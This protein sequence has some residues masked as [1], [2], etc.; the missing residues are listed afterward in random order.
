MYTS[1]QSLNKHEKTHSNPL[2]YK[3]YIYMEPCEILVKG[4][5]RCKVLGPGGVFH[6]IHVVADILYLDFRT[7]PLKLARHLIRYGTF[8][9][10][11]C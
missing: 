2:P 9:D 1:Q 4:Q 3:V 10:P 7:I 6:C 5:C 11:Y 8:R